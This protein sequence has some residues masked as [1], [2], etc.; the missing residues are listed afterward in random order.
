VRVSAIDSS[1]S[2]HLRKA[3]ANNLLPVFVYIK[4]GHIEFRAGQ[5]LLNLTKFLKI[6]VYLYHQISLL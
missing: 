1:S 3:V 2:N 4:E 5:T 6:L